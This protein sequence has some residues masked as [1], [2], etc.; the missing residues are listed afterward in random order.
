MLDVFITEE[1]V[2]IAASIYKAQL[3]GKQISTR[4]IALALFPN[5]IFPNEREKSTYANKKTSYVGRRLTALSTCGLVNIKYV[6]NGCDNSYPLEQFEKVHGE[7]SNSLICPS[8]KKNNNA[9]SI[10]RKFTI[11]G[12]K[13]MLIPSFK[14]PDCRAEAILIKLKKWQAYQL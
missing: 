5:K 8:C 13:V 1:T 9:K 3:Q 11:R 10:S 4:E 6:C 12:D 14:F 7:K 2:L